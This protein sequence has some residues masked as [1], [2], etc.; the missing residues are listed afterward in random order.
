MQLGP[1]DF[2]AGLGSSAAGDGFSGCDQDVAN[3]QADHLI[4]GAGD[5]IGL[6]AER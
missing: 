1:R 5:E 4:C 3:D 6:G 2:V